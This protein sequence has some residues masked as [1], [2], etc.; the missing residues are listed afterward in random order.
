MRLK[1]DQEAYTC[2]YCGSVHV[3]EVN[4]EG[5][6]VFYETAKQNC[7]VCATALVHAAAAGER[8]LYCNRC[9]GMLI[10]MD[11]FP[12]IVQDL[13]S[14]REN[15]AYIPRPFDPR[16]LNR[17]LNC[18]QCGRQMDTHL[19]GGGGNVVIDACENCSVNW[20]DHG[21]LDRIVRAPDREF[22]S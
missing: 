15:S 17:R 18:P 12:E 9:H 16:D 10:S 1:A 4:E 7:P 22:A 5:I 8:V 13:K 6:R 21:E 3:P 2:D 14:H 11:V 20:L 19:F